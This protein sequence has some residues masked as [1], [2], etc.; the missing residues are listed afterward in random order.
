MAFDEDVLLDQDRFLTAVLQRPEFQR[1]MTGTELRHRL[2]AFYT[3][4]ERANRVDRAALHVPSPGDS[5]LRGRARR[6]QRLS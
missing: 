6:R 5:G 4:Q 1:T 3:Q 2:G